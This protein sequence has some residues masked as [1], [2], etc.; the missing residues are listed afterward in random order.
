MAYSQPV[1]GGD[2]ASL[3]A[4]YLIRQFID[5]LKSDLF[6]TDY[7][8]KC[9]VPK[10]AGSYVGRWNLPTF[11]V[12]SI[13]PLTPGSI[14]A[15]GSGV[16]FTPIEAEI[17]DYGDSMT[18][19]DLAH[20][21]SISE[22]LDEYKDIMVY[23][24]ASSINTLLYNQAITSTHF[25]HAGD[26]T[27]DGTTII[28]GNTLSLKDIAVIAKFFRGNDAKGFASLGG[29]FMFA[30]H[31]DA[32]FH[33]V[34]QVPGATGAV[35]TWIDV[36][37]HVPAGY[38]QL[39]KNHRYVGR[40]NGVTV[41]R[42]NLIADVTEDTIASKNNVALADWG[43]GSLG[44]GEKGPTAPKVKFKSPGPHSTNDPLDQIHTLGWKYRMAPKI[45]D[46]ANR[47]LTV[48]SSDA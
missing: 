14:K 27:I 42:T 7:T 15:V 47:A 19:D 26:D 12:G 2:P 25:L 37:K 38:D 6:F 9:K 4:K 43:L 45:L 16:E 48:I 34:T 28:A 20:C 23:E 32:E 24:G 21:A 13:T 35:N 1:V 18:I 40:Y 44:L 8:R 39:V 46:A 33:L 29:D 30:I 10:G 3:F 5:G 41:L 36:N 17:K 22:A 31:P 11:Q